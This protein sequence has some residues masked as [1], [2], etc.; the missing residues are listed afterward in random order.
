MNKQ[1]KPL[2]TNSVRLGQLRSFLYSYE[3][4]SFSKAAKLM[5]VSQSAITKN[6]KSL[7]D[8]FNVKLFHRDTRNFELT[9]AANKLYPIVHAL[10]FQSDALDECLNVIDCGDYGEVRIGFD[11]VFAPYGSQL[12]TNLFSQQFPEMKISIVDDH[13]SFL[14][15]KLLKGKMDFYIYYHGAC[16]YVDEA[17]HLVV[18]PLLDLQPLAVVS[19]EAEFLKNEEALECYKW[20]CPK[21]EGY[22]SDHNFWEKYQEIKDKGN[23]MYEIDSNHTRIDLAVEGVAATI[24]P[25][26]TVKQQLASGKLIPLPIELDPIRLSVFYLKTNPIEKKY[27]L[28]LDNFVKRFNDFYT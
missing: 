24:L 19:P 10:C 17:E 3:T 22:F 6:I 2:R 14:H 18:Q 20:V 1:N 9:K 28:I 7:E 15:Q 13:I 8:H 27:K 23:I 21:V 26:F 4:C 11:R 16:N 25:S 12:L 5:G